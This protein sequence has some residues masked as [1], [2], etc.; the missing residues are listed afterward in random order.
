MV[1]IIVP[2]YNHEPYLRQR[3]DTVFNQT[4]IDFEV[5]LLDDCSTDN[6][7]AILAEYSN[8]PQVSHFIVNKINSG[9]PFKQWRKGIEL[10]KYDYIWI[11]ESDDYNETTFLEN[12]IPYFNI[13]IGIV[14]SSLTIVE[15]NKSTLYEALKIGEHNGKELLRSKMIT[16]NLFVNANCV[17]FN[18]NFLD[19]KHLRKIEN[20]TICGDWFS[21]EP[22]IN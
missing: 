10:S 18:K 12:L 20:F 21:L 2:N 11:A 19:N 5:I 16:G 1:S 6:S 7:V 13:N 15:K 17:V 14:F 3:L 9:S 8:K 4:F 22:N